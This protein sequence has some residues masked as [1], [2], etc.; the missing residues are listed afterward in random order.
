MAFANMACSPEEPYIPDV[1]VHF[2]CLVRTVLSG[3]GILS[4]RTM[5]GAQLRGKLSS[6]GASPILGTLMAVA[7]WRS[8]LTSSQFTTS[9]YVFPSQVNIVKSVGAHTNAQFR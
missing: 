9:Q 8:E 7:T 2:D 4:M 6:C 5:E 1:G 3:L